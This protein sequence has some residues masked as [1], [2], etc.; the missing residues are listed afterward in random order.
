MKKILV[1]SVL[2]LSTAS[3]AASNSAVN[4]LQY[5]P[6]AGTVFGDTSFN[7]VKFTDTEFDGTNDIRSTLKGYILRQQIGY[8][9]LNNFSL[10]LDLGYTDT[11]SEA[12]GFDTTKSSGLNDIGMLGKYRVI[13]TENRLDLLAN[14]TVSPGDS[15]T[16]SN[17]DSNSFTGGHQA[18]V[19]AEY[20]AKKSSHQW[21]VRA[22]YTYLF[23]ST[24][25]DK[26]STPTD[27]YKDDAHSQLDFGANL[28]T[29]LSET[30]YIKTSAS[31]QFEQEYED[32]DNNETMG[33]TNY[34]LGAEYQHLM[35]KDLYLRGGFQSAIGGNGY[36]S[37]V[38][39]YTLG[40]GY[41]F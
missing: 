41:Q 16:K 13:D 1:L 24:V 26:S 12:T 27:T 39:L 2:A 3:F 28:L 14:V 15:E 35:S 9:L 34:I 5:L 20:G 37:V 40:A 7:Y 4:D 11:K 8:S 6:D 30:S 21:S 38:M 19:G 32:D 31:V 25:K 10:T 33:S 22:L 17:G 18:A 23:E 29:Q 36:N